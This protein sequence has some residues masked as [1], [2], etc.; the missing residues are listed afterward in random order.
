MIISSVMDTQF[1]YKR[2]VAHGW[3]AGTDVKGVT[4]GRGDD[5]P[6]FSTDQ[7]FTY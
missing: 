7:R 5:E 2:Q 3:W 6:P 4:S 1:D